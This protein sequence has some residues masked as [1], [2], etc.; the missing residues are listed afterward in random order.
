MLESYIYYSNHK[1]EHIWLSEG[2]A[3]DNQLGAYTLNVNMFKGQ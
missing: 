2:Q 3:H 1:G